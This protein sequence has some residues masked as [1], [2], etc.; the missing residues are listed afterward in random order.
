MAGDLTTH[1][2]V[3]GLFVNFTW[4]KPDLTV[5]EMS[6]VKH[7]STMYTDVFTGLL[8]Y[9]AFTVSFIW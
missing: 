3:L 9:A 4:T 2:Q 8:S 1:E 7:W 5:G 6:V